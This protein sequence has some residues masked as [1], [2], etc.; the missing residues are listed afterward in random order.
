VARNRKIRQGEIYWLDNCPALDGHAEKRRPIVVIGHIDPANRTGP[1]LVVG[2]SHT[3]STPDRDPDLLRLPDRQQS[4]T[5]KTGLSRSSWAIPRWFLL[6]E[7]ERFGDPCGHI[8]GK[9]L[10]RLVSAV[11]TRVKET[12]ESS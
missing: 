6:V 10:K 8:K 3:A 12:E 7:P 9:L 1:V 2:I 5:V 11:L 4:P